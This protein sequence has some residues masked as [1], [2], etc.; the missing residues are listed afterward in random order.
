MKANIGTG[1]ESQ[2]V[3]EENRIEGDPVLFPIQM[4]RAFVKCV[5]RYFKT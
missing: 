1:I 5:G 3:E 4:I 2:K